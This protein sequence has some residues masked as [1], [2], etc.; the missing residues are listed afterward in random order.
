MCAFNISCPLMKV[1]YLSL[2]IFIWLMNLFVSCITS[3]LCSCWSDRAHTLELLHFTVAHLS[4]PWTQQTYHIWNLHVLGHPVT[5]ALL[6]DMI[7]GTSSVTTVK[8]TESMC[9]I[10]C[11]LPREIVFAGLIVQNSFTFLLMMTVFSSLLYS[12][13]WYA[14]EWWKYKVFVSWEILDSHYLYPILWLLIILFF[15]VRNTYF[16]VWHLNIN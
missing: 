16:V 2:D 6:M 15:S 14:I 3:F 12:F 7:K 4:C 9:V 10:K 1:H 8:L 5:A 13:L 11:I